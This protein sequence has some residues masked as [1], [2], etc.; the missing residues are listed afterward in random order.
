MKYL[1]ISYDSDEQ[2]SFFDHVSA[3]SAEEAHTKVAKLRE[4]AV[5]VDVLSVDVLEGIRI[6][7]VMRTEE[8]IAE[9]W[10]VVVA[11]ESACTRCGGP[12]DDDC[13]SGNC[14]VKP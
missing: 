3:E 6:A 8:Q 1:V 13:R 14:E 2:Q 9:E 10:E 4:D 7:L 5:V 12:V 11:D